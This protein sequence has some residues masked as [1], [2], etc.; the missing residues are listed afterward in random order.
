M[1]SR[2]RWLVGGAV[3]AAL[4]LAAGVAAV[5]AQSG[6]DGGGSSFLDRVAAKLGIDTPRLEQAIDDARNDQIDQ[7]VQDGDLTEEQA[8]RLRDRLEGLPGDA[9]FGGPFGGP[10]GG[11]G[12]KFRHRPDGDLKFGFFP[13]G[14]RPGQSREALATFV[15]ITTDQLNAQLAADGATLATVA[16]ANGKSRD[17]LKAFIRG[18]A[19]SALNEAVDGGRLTRER[20]D[21]LLQRLDEHIDRL[22]DADWGMGRFH[23]KFGPDG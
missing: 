2:R 6:D 9:P 14:L 10:G 13:P 17:D 18:E 7:A 16:E 5:G 22:I 1:T 20:A 4:V 23:F 8:Q 12:S 11:F 19:E 21:A 3:G 15:G